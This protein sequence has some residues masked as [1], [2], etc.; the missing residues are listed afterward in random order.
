MSKKQTSN[1]FDEGLVKDYHPLTVPNNTLTDALNATFVTMNGNEA[2]LQNDMGNG[3]VESAFLP[4]GYVPVGMKEYGGIIYVASYNPIT[5]KSQL[6]CF[7]S[8]ERN[9]DQ[10]ETGN[11]ETVLDLVVAKLFLLSSTTSTNFALE[12]TSLTQ[13][14][15]SFASVKS[16]SFSVV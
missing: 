5:N 13:A 10:T 9:I 4:N 8:P 7:P 11:P 12:S 14:S 15:V 3:R 1:T 16:I 6:G 2:I